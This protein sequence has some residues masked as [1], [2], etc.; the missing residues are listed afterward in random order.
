MKANLPWICHRCGLAISRE[1]TARNPRHKMAWSADHH[2][3]PR[4][5][6][7]QSVKENMKP[8]HNLCNSDAGNALKAAQIEAAANP[9]SR[10][11]GI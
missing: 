2:P 4:S 10:V 9:R 7:G 5:E 1:I 6:G 8:A 11:W 3:V